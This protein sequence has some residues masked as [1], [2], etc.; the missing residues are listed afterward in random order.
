N[1]EGFYI[2]SK[3]ELI[4]IE[5]L[6]GDKKIEKNK[7]SITLKNNEIIKLEL[8]N[9]IKNA[10]EK[11]V[12]FWEEEFIN[13]LESEFNINFSSGHIIMKI[14]KEDKIRFNKDEENNTLK[15]EF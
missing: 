14:S 4:Y 1:S 3:N 9:T 11:Y 2:K 13:P 15:N 6:V 12:W 8:Y 10:I 7:E 5:F